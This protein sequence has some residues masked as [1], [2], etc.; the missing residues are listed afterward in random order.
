MQGSFND[1]RAYAQLK[2]KLEA[3]DQ[4]FGIPGS[5][6][7]YLSVPPSLVEMSVAHLKEAG[8][9]ADPD[10]SPPLHARHRGEADRPGP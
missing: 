1:S 5:R 6:V 7:Y 2:A 4:Q 10:G 3:V 9:V 8:M